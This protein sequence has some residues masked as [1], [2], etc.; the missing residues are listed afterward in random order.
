MHNL[1]EINSLNTGKE[2]YNSIVEIYICTQL[3]VHKSQAYATTCVEGE[4][5][6]Y[7]ENSFVQLP[8][9]RFSKIFVPVIH[10]FHFTFI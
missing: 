5:F 7:N 6:F 8:V 10:N 3:F 2:L 9:E 4:S 1:L